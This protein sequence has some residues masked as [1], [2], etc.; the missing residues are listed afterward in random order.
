MITTFA[1][2]LTCLLGLLL[3]HFWNG[4]KL[5]P[6]PRKRRKRKEKTQLP[7]RPK[8][9]IRSISY[10]VE[11]MLLPMLVII[12]TSELAQARSIGHGQNESV[13]GSTL[14]SNQ[15]TPMHPVR[16]LILK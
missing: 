4:K 5:S 9:A 3:C 2:S 8:M 15:N 12:L 11:L 7:A 13:N 16:S 14:S 10:Y 6:K 1:P